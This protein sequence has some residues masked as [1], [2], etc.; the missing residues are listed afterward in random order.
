MDCFEMQD[1][2]NFNTEAQRA[3]RKRNKKKKIT[4]L[5]LRVLCASVLNK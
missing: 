2:E 5:N 4:Y 3:Q 1:Y